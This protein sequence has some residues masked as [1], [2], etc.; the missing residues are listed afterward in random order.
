[1]PDD[2]GTAQLH[3]RRGE[4]AALAAAVAGAADGRGAVVLVEGPPGI[5]KT[6]L[7]GA[8][9][10]LARDAGL[11]VLQACGAQFERDEPFGVVRQLLERELLT[12]PPQRRALLLDGVA[13]H[14]ERVF[15]ADPAAQA[16][17]WAV[18]HGLYWL[19]AN[20]AAERPVFI[21][22]DDLHWT[23]AASAR[24]LGY[25]ARRSSELP[26]VL[27]CGLR[28]REVREPALHELH[29][30][31]HTSLLEP[32]PLTPGAIAA[33]LAERYGEPVDETFARAC[34]AATGGNPFLLRELV[35]ALRAEGIAPTAETAAQVA[36]LRP[37]A[38][39]RSLAA[40]LAGLPP[41]ARQLAAAVAVLGDGARLG[42]AA[43][44]AGVEDPDTAYAALV[45]TE[46]LAEEL[47]LA[48]R[49]PLL[50]AAVRGDLDPARLARLHERAIDALTASGAS[51]E[52]IAHHVVA[53]EPRGDHDRWALL[54]A[55]GRSAMDRGAPDAAL[56][57][58]ERALL[59]PPPADGRAET[60]RLLG[61]AAAQVSR[62]AEAQG[63]LRAAIAL[64]DD[65]AERA[66]MWLALVRTTMV[67]VSVAAG[68]EVGREGLA[69]LAGAAG[70]HIERLRTELVCQ[71]ATHPATAALA[72]DL[73]PGADAPAGATPEER[74]ALLRLVLGDARGTGSAARTI[75]L[76]ER[77]VA[78]GALVEE[79]TA[80]SLALAQIAQ[81]LAYA[82]ACTA[83]V[84]FCEDLDADARR[85][86]ATWGMVAASA[87]LGWVRLR[88]GDV[89]AAEADAR[90]ALAPGILPLMAQP[91]T[92]AS[93]VVALTWSGQLE[94]AEE[95]VASSG[96]GPDTD[97]LVH[98]AMLFLARGWLRRAQRRHEEALEDFREYGRRVGRIGWDVPT[99]AWR[100]EA[101]EQLVLLDRAGEAVDL[102]HDQLDV[103]R[104]WGAP[105]GIAAGLRALGLARGPAGL[106]HLEE[107]VAVLADS[108]VRIERVRALLALGAAQRR[109][110][111]RRAAADTLAEALDLA[112][113]CSAGWYAT[114]AE[115]ELRRLGL[116]PRSRRVSGPEALTASERRVC[117]LA[118]RGLSNREIAQELFVTAKTVENH[119]GRAYG[120]LGI[121]SRDALAEALG[122]A[123]V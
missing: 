38:T 119:L 71:G 13:E 72:A 43:A 99:F 110:G 70:V 8:T 7:L 108:P 82:D 1:M 19:V 61:T 40:R 39:R 53:V 10:E 54:L 81:H 48:F 114:R 3:E 26:L 78:G 84:A 55:A 23:D 27:G 89:G 118:A 64:T 5:G 4:L 123:P 57:L 109:D 74:L 83:A 65:A 44:V 87:C 94:E 95:V 76:C 69:D 104:V 50:R 58:L 18:L 73:R 16:D 116:R 45:R 66:T 88:E 121:G 120:K 67:G 113:R 63:W 36:D 101:A 33:I 24:F 77:A 122:A 59:E 115:E 9:A 37:A 46:I 92:V 106:A 49:H 41:A 80:E 62:T 56:P 91:F 32:E 68:V 17:L 105:T 52:R 112:D 51:A 21:S 20:L 22:V 35:S 97:E 90:R 47:P 93:L 2:R 11:T 6:R 34:S 107:A 30:L 42:T 85:R 111:A 75:E 25:L 60:L 98:A 15:S 102:A 117:E 12:A 79:E 14:A 100:A 31:P 96:C 29:L 86:G 103:A 28:P